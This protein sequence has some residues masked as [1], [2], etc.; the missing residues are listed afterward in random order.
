MGSVQG[1]SRRVDTLSSL[2]LQADA[3]REMMQGAA[4]DG[5]GAMV[6]RLK[7]RYMAVPPHELCWCA[8]QVVGQLRRQPA[9]GG[10]VVSS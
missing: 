1:L 7:R 4:K 6:E 9:C 5:V 2:F 8:G 3:R 10:G